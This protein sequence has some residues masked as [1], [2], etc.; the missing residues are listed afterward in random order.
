VWLTT[1]PD[2]G[3]HGLSIS[4]ET[5]EALRK[6][7]KFRHGRDFPEGIKPL[8]KRAV[9]IKVVIPSSDRALKAWLPYARKR[10]EPR[11]LQTLN[12]TGG[13]KANAQTWWLYFGTITPDQ[14]AAVDIL[15][16]RT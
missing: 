11:W 14:F 1:D 4:E 8:N 7:I 12:E 3:D 16:H 15:E 5:R 6:E 9:R 13:G 10:L 2:A